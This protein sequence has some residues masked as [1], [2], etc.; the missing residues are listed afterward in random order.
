LAGNVTSHRCANGNSYL[1]GAHF[2]WSRP[3]SGVF[4]LCDVSTGNE[5]GRL[6]QQGFGK[7]TAVNDDA[8]IALIGSPKSGARFWFVRE[9]RTVDAGVDLYG[10]VFAGPH[11]LVGEVQGKV[12]TV[13]PTNK[14]TTSPGWEISAA[15]GE[16][17]LAADLASDLAVVSGTQPTL[18]R[19]S[20]GKVIAKLPVRALHAATFGPNGELL[21]SDY[22][23][24]WFWRPPSPEPVGELHIGPTGVLF[25]ASNGK[26][27][28]SD[29][30]T[31]W[32][33]SLSCHVGPETLPVAT[34]IENL[35]ERGLLQRL[36]AGRAN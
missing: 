24:I 7:V 34:C 10:S 5:L 9:K 28:A 27:E 12:I 1:V 20:D 8:T 19:I 21:A 31:N 22:Q 26:F 11:T 2:T 33:S 23:R 13:N 3:D 36:L 25:I 16:F 14:E 15:R 17:L 6:E 35:Y 4:V 32:Q 18:R 29:P 30:V